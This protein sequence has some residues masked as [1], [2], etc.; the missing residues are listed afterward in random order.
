[1]SSAAVFI[2]IAAFAASAAGAGSADDKQPGDSLQLPLSRS[3]STFCGPSG[4]CITC[5]G[6]KTCD[7][8]MKREDLAA[9]D[10]ALDV[11]EDVAPVGD[12]VESAE[13]EQPDNSLRR[14]MRGGCATTCGPYGCTTTCTRMKRE[15]LAEID[16]ALGANEGDNSLR[17]RV[18]G[19]CATTCG[20]YG[21][22]TTCTR[23]KRE[24]LAEIDA[25]LGANEAAPVGDNVESTAAGAGSA[26]NEQPDN[27]LRRRMRGGCATTCGP[28][29]CTSTCTRMKRED[30]AALDTRRSTGSN[31]QWTCVCIIN[32]GQSYGTTATNGRC[33]S[34]LPRGATCQEEQTCN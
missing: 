6:R 10:A 32:D 27:S 28:Y 21:C 3:C 2:V 26:E 17:R 24:D 9:L 19:G 12:N 25:A 15:D 1:M 22:T 7:H 34:S 5:D 14:R 20:P 13:N 23:M 8:R 33:R 29:G 31:C 11:N 4:C 18:R 16:A 30:L